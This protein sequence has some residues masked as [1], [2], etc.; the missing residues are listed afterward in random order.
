M[1]ANTFIEDIRWLSMLSNQDKYDGK[2]KYDNSNPRLPD[3]D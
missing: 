3:I 1:I 2:Y